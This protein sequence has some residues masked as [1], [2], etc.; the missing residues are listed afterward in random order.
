MQRLVPAIV[1][2]WLAAEESLVDLAIGSEEAR[3][4]AERIHVLQSAHSMA[5]APGADRESVVRFLEEH[6]AGD[7]VTPPAMGAIGSSTDTNRLRI[8]PPRERRLRSARLPV[9]SGPATQSRQRRTSTARTMEQY[10][11]CATANAA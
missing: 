7:I 6:G 9:P 3:R 5:T 10:P 11:I 1:D 4:A 2:A 8:C